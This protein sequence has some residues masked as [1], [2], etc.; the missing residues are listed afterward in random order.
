MFVLQDMV[1]T[2]LHT[3][4]GVLWLNKTLIV[5]SDVLS[6]FLAFF[7]SVWENNPLG[8]DGP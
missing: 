1:R 6:L 7:L 4:P 8:H 5:F 3:C 2:F